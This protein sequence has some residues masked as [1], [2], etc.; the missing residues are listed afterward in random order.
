MTTHVHIGIL[1]PLQVVVRGSPVPVTSP[2]QATLLV[3]LALSPGAVVSTDRLVDLLWGDAPPPS[4]VNS[5]QSHL[6]RLRSRLESPELVERVGAGYR[7][8]IDHRDVDAT[9]FADLVAVARHAPPADALTALDEA[10]SLWRGDDLG[11]LVDHPFSAEQAGLAAQRVEALETRGRLR[12]DHGDH[13]GAITDLHGV[14]DLEPL[15]DTAV[16]SLV[17]ALA[18][19]GRLAEADRAWRAHR[20]R[21]A[22]ELGLDPSPSLEALHVALLR[23]EL[24][25]DVATATRTV[26]SSRPPRPRSRLVGREDAVA[27]VRHHLGQSPITTIVGPGGV[28]K[29]RLATEVVVED[30][31]GTVVWVDLTDA[32]DVGDVH[33]RIALALGARSGSGPRVLDGLVDA[34]GSRDL[35]LVVDNCEHVVDDTAGLVDGLLR[36]APGLKVLATSREPLRIDGERVVRLAPLSDRVGGEARPPALELLLDRAGDLIDADDPDHLRLALEITQRLDGLPLALEL[37]ARQVPNLGLATLHEQLAG[38]LD[39]LAGGR[40]PHPAHRDLRALVEWSTDLLD[41]EEARA[42]TELAVLAGPFDLDMAGRLLA[43]STPPVQRVPTVLAALVERSLVARDDGVGHRLL[44]TVRNILLARLPAAARHELAVRHVDA[45][46][47]ILREAAAALESDREPEAVQRLDHLVPDLQA[48]VRWVRDHRDLERAAALAA[49][50]HRYASRTQRLELL[51]IGSIAAELVDAARPDARP[52]AGPDARPDA[53]PDAEPGRQSLDGATAADALAAAAWHALCLG[54]FERAERRALQALEA[55]SVACPGVASAW[56]VLGDLHLFQGRA[57]QALRASSE[58]VRTGEALDDDTLQANG[59]IGVALVH[60]W[61]LADEPARVAADHQA[62]LAA[63]N[64]APSL[65]AWASYLRGEM[66]ADRAPELAL[67]AFDDAIREA[68]AVANLDITGVARTARSAVQARHGPPGAALAGFRDALERW[69]RAGDVARRRTTLRNLFVLLARVGQ[70]QA[71]IMLDAAD[72][73]PHMYP[74]ERRR[75][76]Q[77]RQTVVHRLGADRAERLRADARLLDAPAL[78]DVALDA[79]RA[80]ERQSAAGTTT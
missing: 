3:A 36:V 73:Q 20:D 38:S 25:A 53:R 78:V 1:G 40:S 75:V 58:L 45:V 24:S 56:E 79:I 26:L 31:P 44:D 12:L 46:S 76:E 51:A 42:L 28:G 47:S 4:A 34:L 43:T 39:L 19:T 7:L 18:A 69:H 62:R 41:P 74:A 54:D 8:A 30:V 32:G 35:L 17:R 49:S 37:A 9:R 59:W 61:M 14:L 6:T 48:A 16:A 29:T 22:D 27:A 60:V 15:R 77:A 64:G 21:L 5:L 72:D 55:T 70:D 66:E 52:D 23:G 67:A 33:G 63:R 13:A 10:L 80:A 68:E 2:H 71:A 65:H 57:E 11:G 50:L